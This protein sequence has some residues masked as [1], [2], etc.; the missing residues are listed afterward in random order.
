MPT[1]RTTGA[2]RQAGNRVKLQVPAFSFFPAWLFTAVYA[3]LLLCIPARLVVGPIGAPGTPAALAAIAGLLW[4]CCAVLGGLNH[5]RGL[6]PMRIAVA[7]LTICTLAS[8]V[9]GH[10]GGWYQP[11]DI[12]QRTDRLWRAAT[13]SE[14]TA[15]AA[16][17]ADRGLLALAGWVGIALITSEGIRS[18][19]ELERVIAWIVAAA[20]F[21]ASLGIVQYFTGISL[22]RYLQIPGLTPMSNFGATFSRS[23]L[24]RVVSTSGHPIELGV[25]M[26]AILP[27]ALHRSLHSTRR[28]AWIPTLLIGLTALMSVSRSAIV[29]AAVALIVMFAGWP[30][31]W[32]LGALI[33]APIAAVVGRAALPGLLGTIRSLFTNLE[34]DPSIDGRTADYSLVFRLVDERPVFGQ[35]LFTFIPMVYRTLDNQA[36]VLLLELGVVGTL[37]FVGLIAVGVNNAWAPRRLGGEAQHRHLGLAVAA[38]LIGIVTS[39]FTFDALGFRQVAGLTFLLIGLAGAIWQLT[40]DPLTPQLSPHFSTVDDVARDTPTARVS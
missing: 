8:Y 14:V 28:T 15:T 23:I 12:H 9:A 39:Y 35:G 40:R 11:A 7:L 34:D 36:L 17:A 33:A 13:A 30:N 25:I 26:A 29:V 18:W 3:L 27:L 21:V 37:A 19:R 16:S 4:W 22:A 10:L 2:S 6:S 31:R 38:S 20:S 1:K 32:R 24:N 5:R